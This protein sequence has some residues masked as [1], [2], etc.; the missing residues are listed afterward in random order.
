MA[1]SLDSGSGNIVSGGDGSDGDLILK[2]TNGQNRVNLDA[3]GSKIWL[4]GNGEPGDFIIFPDSGDNGTLSQSSIRLRGA[5]G[6]ITAGGS[7]ANGKILLKADGGQNRIRLDSEGGNV[8]LGGNGKD[9]DLILFSSSGDNTTLS[10][11]TIHLN[12]DSGDIVLQNA[13]CAEDFTIEEDPTVEPGTVMVINDSGTLSKSKKEYDKC[14]AGIIAGAGS[15]KP[16]IILGRSASKEN[17]WPIA[18]MGR[19]YCKVDAEF[20]AIERGDLLTTSGNPGYAMK[21][22]DSVRAFGSVIGK[23]LNSLK[24]GRDLVQVLVSLQ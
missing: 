10:H 3:G 9:G 1:L 16:G 13:D 12:G 22:T 4:G 23:A 8:W 17:Q 5:D 2:S 19:V 6:S 18:L 14:V 11:A 21:A 24:K 7:G 15:L 20:G